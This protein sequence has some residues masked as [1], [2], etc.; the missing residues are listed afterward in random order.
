MRIR[1]W[2]RAILIASAVIA[3]V[4]VAAAPNVGARSTNKPIRLLVVGNSLAGTLEFGSPRGLVPHGLVAQPGFEI[5]DRTLLAC[6]ISSAPTFV[7]DGM[8]VANRCGGAQRW[9]RQWPGDVAAVRPDAV[10]VMAGGQDVYDVAGP[11]GSVI[12]PGDPVWTARYT[13]DVRQMFTILHATGAPVIAAVPPSCYGQNTLDPADSP[14]TAERF[15]PKR[16]AAVD[17]SWRAAARETKTRM[18]DMGSTICPGGVSDPALRPDGVHFGA[19]GADRV[20][21]I[22]TRAVRRALARQAP[23]SRARARTDQASG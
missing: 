11:D 1:G 22:V 5:V 6:S 23:R 18:V 17:N 7:L 21:P 16:L 12:H 14:S 9:Q 2:P 20:A 15:D 13:A 19:V 10:F 8:P 4:F 3:V